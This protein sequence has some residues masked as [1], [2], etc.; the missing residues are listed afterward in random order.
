MNMTARLNRFVLGAFVAALLAVLPARAQAPATPGPEHEAMKKLEGV[1]L[2]K[3]IMP[4]GE[5]K[6]TLTAKMEC[7]DLWMVTDFQGEFGGMKFQGRGLDSYDA[8]KK[9][10]ISVW[11]DSF[12]TQPM[13]FEGT[14]NKEKKTQTMI[15]EGPGPDGKPVKYKSETTFTDDDHHTFVMSM[16]DADGKDNK[17]MTIEYTRKK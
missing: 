3:T 4:D 8:A 13:I 17:M 9:K 11:V 2:A 5:S 7:G 10:Y 6:G 16:V 14:M 15:G 1:W 12:S